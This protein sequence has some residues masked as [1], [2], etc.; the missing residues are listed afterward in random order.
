MFPLQFTHVTIETEETITTTDPSS[1]ASLVSRYHRSLSTTAF[2]DNNNNN[3]DNFDVLRRI[4]TPHPLLPLETAT[5]IVTQY[6]YHPLE[7]RHRMAVYSNSRTV[8]VKSINH[9]HDDDDDDHDDGNDDTTI[10]NDTTNYNKN[11]KNDDLHASFELDAPPLTFCWAHLPLS[12]TTTSSSSSTSTTTTQQPEQQPQQPQPHAVLCVLCN[13]TT[14]AIWD[15][16]PIQND[17]IATTTSSPSCLSKDWMV[18]LPFECCNMLPLPW[19]PPP[20][21]HSNNNHAAL[22]HRMRAG[23]L[24][25]RQADPAY[26]AP[27][28]PAVAT[29]VDHRDKDNHD[30]QAQQH[31]LENNNNNNDNNDNDNKDSDDF[32]GASSVLMI[33]SSLGTTTMMHNEEEEEGDGAGAGDGDGD[34]GHGWVQAGTTV[35]PNHLVPVASLFSLEHPRKMSCPFGR[36]LQLMPLIPMLL[37]LHTGRSLA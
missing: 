33:H 24:L 6:E 25:Q 16:Y 9:Q 27:V 28:V 19:I 11:N 35:D 1:V 15:V 13:A 10:T 37:L 8:F 18:T 34:V 22:F 3:H 14:L 36:F 26:D 23:L 7:E 30:Q 20:V 2:P 21:N 31:T 4:V 5:T 32:P 29:A 17:T 12:T